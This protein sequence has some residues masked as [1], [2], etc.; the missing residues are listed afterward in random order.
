[1]TA[2]PVHIHHIYI[3]PA[4]NYFGHHGQAA[5]EYDTM[6]CTEV[7]CVAGSGIVGDRFFNYKPDYKGQITFFEWAIYLEMLEWSKPKHF[8]SSAYRRNVLIEG[9]QL[10]SLIGKQFRLGNALFHGSEECK[11][12]YWMDEAVGAGAEAML[13]GKGGLRARIIESGLLTQGPHK[14]EIIS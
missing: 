9:I 5:G 13:K 12:C 6:E 4:H 14:L 11:P 8:P 1:M 7:E 2:H 10:D 3:S